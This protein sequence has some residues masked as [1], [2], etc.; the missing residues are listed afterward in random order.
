MPRPYLYYIT[1]R[2]Q[3]PG[4]EQN[5]RKQLL[6]TI[7]HAARSGVDFVQLR[8]KDLSAREV[9]CLAAEALAEIQK[10][11]PSHSPPGTRLLINSRL[12]IALAVDA[13]GVH[14]RSDDIAVADARKIIS[15][16]GNPSFLAAASCHSPV[17]VERSAA[18]GADFVVFAPVFEK[19]GIESA[20][21]AGLSRLGEACRVGIP[22]LALGGI[23]L[24]NAAVC[25]R[26]GASGVAGIRLFQRSSMQS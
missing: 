21:P 3:F 4:S 17:E 25:I 24:D 19:S 7:G 16:A 13:A 20:S 12:D 26:A 18:E 14:L 11:L 1:D 2:T 6:A 8:E 5:R 15:A 22:V 10:N 23:T 9:E